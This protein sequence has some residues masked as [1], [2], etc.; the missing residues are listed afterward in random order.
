MDST[1]EAS[2]G[3]STLN[4]QK[5]GVP[6]SPRYVLYIN[7]GRN[8]HRKAH[9]VH[10]VC[11]RYPGHE[12]YITQELYRWYRPGHTYDLMKITG[13][14]RGPGQ[15]TYS[16]YM[17]YKYRFVCARNKDPSNEGRSVK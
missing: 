2:G 5:V 9:T 1:L 15:Q 3:I 17:R 7:I 8:Y 10:G 12:M 6:L 13:S 11:S 4:I 16:T 14:A